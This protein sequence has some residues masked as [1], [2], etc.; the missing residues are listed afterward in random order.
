[1]SNFKGTFSRIESRR[2]AGT[3]I[4]S[5]SLKCTN[6]MFGETVDV[7]I[8]PSNGGQPWYFRDLKFK[9][10]ETYVFN[11]DTVD[12]NWCQGDW[13]AI[14]GK[15]DRIIERWPLQLKEYKPGE[16]PSCHGTH[17]C[18]ACNGQ[19]FIYPRCE[20]WNYQRCPQCGGTGICQ[21]CYVPRR[22]GG[23]GGGPSGLKPF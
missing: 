19:G 11:F 22:S 8:F 5:F 1:M 14:V 12:W 23:S 13:A 10:G 20:T 9:A 3:I 6:L 4:I 15:N 2:L 18:R 21:T 17:K 16:C 7:A